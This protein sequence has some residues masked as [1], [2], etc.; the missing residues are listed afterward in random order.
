MEIVTTH[1]PNAAA[2][3]NRIRS[4]IYALAPYESFREVALEIAD[5]RADADALGHFIPKG[6]GKPWP[7][8]EGQPMRRA[9]RKAA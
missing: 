6:F 8:Q 3:I 2:E 4:E 5:L 7:K 1:L 9:P